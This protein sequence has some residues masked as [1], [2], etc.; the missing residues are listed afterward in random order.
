[1]ALVNFY[2]EEVVKMEQIRKSA[3][4]MKSA[5]DE[6]E[7]A[8]INQHTLR[9]LSADEVFT[10]KLAASNNQ[11][12]RDWERFTDAA[13]E[14]MAE[15]YVGKPVIR[16]HDWKHGC[17]TARVYAAN[18]V[19]ADGGV[20]Q[21]ILRC[22]MP[23]TEGNA[24]TI[25]AI[26]SGVLRECSVSVIV[27]RVVCSVCGANQREAI[28]RHFPGRIYDG[29]TCHF[30]LDDVSDVYEVSLVAIPANADAGVVKAKRYGGAD[31]EPDSQSWQ[32]KALLE[33]EKNRFVMEGQNN[34]TETD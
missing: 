3:V 1:M 18:V 33:L 26:E 15:L 11:I 22:Y 21:L 16:N 6:Q 25:T 10:F 7:M 12:D 20:K 23:R 4:L 8:L 19:A 30:D 13:L 29:V 14:K 28:C 27:K 9:E 32:D 24:E 31:P 2:A 17:Q 34:E 5:I